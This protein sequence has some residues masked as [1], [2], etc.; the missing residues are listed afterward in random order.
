M[1]KEGRVEEHEPPDSDKGQRCVGRQL[2]GQGEGSDRRLALLG[3]VDRGRRKVRG[4]EAHEGWGNSVQQEEGRENEDK[5]VARDVMSSLPD[6]PP[7]FIPTF[8]TPLIPL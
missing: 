5:D 2:D 4:K 1:K 7:M 8:P 6:V 3:G